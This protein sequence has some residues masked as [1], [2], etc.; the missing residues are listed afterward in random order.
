MAIYGVRRLSCRHSA[1]FY[2][3]TRPEEIALLIGVVAGANIGAVLAITAPTSRNVSEE[4]QPYHFSRWALELLGATFSTGV[5]LSLLIWRFWLHSS[6]GWDLARSLGVS[7]MPALGF[8]G[9][10]SALRFAYLDWSAER[11]IRNLDPEVA[12]ALFGVGVSPAYNIEDRPTERRQHHSS[13]RAKILL[14][15]WQRVLT[16]IAMIG[17]ASLALWH[18]F[19]SG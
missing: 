12:A 18:I 5:A 11:A 6:F 3:S 2:M 15:I 9:V 13:V 10:F 1:K 14:T 16:A 8:R 4:L 17:P 19:F 7:I